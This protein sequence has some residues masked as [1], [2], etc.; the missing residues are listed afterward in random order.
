MINVIFVM[1]GHKYT[2][3]QV[4]KL[5]QQL[6]QYGPDY[7]YYVCTDRPKA[8]FGSIEVIEIPPQHHLHTVWNKLWMFSEEF[9][10]KGPCLYFDIDTIIRKDPFQVDIPREDI[11]HRYLRMVDCHWKWPSLVRLT[12]YDVLCNSSVLAWNSNNPHIHFIWNHFQYSG[13]RDYFVKK[14]VG[15]DRY[16]VHEC[17]GGPDYTTA[18][19]F[20]PQEYIRSHK[21]ELPNKDAPVVTFEEV[22]FGLIDPKQIA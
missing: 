13:Q 4:K 18:I 16:L 3:T 10:V 8:D 7:K 22:D 9:P 20:F 2:P 11:T 14:Y 15:I 5:H 1:V 21:Y 17:P 19:C 12:N 6:V